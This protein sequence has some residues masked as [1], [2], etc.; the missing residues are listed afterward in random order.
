MITREDC[1]EQS[2]TN[3]LRTSILVDRAYPD[4]QVEFRESFPYELKPDEFD[5]NIVTVGFNFDDQGTQAEMGSSL[6]RRLYTIEFWVFGKTNTYGRNLANAVKFSLER[7]GII[8]LFDIASTPP[9]QIDALIVEGVNVDRQI[10][11]EPEPWQQF[12]WT[13]TLRVTD[14][15]YSLLA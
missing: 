1:I 3:Y 7:D 9:V 12:V 15:Y 11:P 13:S 5:K 8:P 4:T 14:E 10:V 6:K 2:V